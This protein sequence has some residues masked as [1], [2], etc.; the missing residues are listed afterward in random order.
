M[1]QSTQPLTDHMKFLR[2]YY[3]KIGSELSSDQISLD[4]F[5]SEMVENHLQLE[6]RADYDG[7]LPEF[8]NHSGFEKTINRELTILR[9]RGGIKSVL[10]AL[11]I[12]QLKRFNDQEGH[13]SG[14]KLIKI[15]ADV[16]LTQTRTAD[17]K[18]RLGG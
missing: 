6:K 4:K 16:M 7:L 11:D 14:D 12:D 3:H 17:L 5:I 18:A 15:Y 1:D 2:D 13:L 10:M 9:R 8:L